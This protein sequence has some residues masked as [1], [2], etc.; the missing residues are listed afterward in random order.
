MSKFDNSRQASFRIEQPIS[1]TVL[2]IQVTAIRHQ[3]GR[4]GLCKAAQRHIDVARCCCRCRTNVGWA[5]RLEHAASPFFSFHDIRQIV[6]AYRRPIIQSVSDAVT[7]DTPPPFEAADSLIADGALESAH[8]VFANR[9]ATLTVP[10]LLLPLIDSF[11]IA[12]GSG[13][14]AGATDSCA[15]VPIRVLAVLIFWAGLYQLASCVVGQRSQFSGRVARAASG[16]IL[17]VAVG[18]VMIAQVFFWAFVAVSGHT[19]SAGT[20]AFVLNNVS[21]LVRHL[22]QTSPAVAIGL[23]ATTI[24]ASV[25]TMWLLVATGNDRPRGIPFRRLVFGILLLGAWQVVSGIAASRTPPDAYLGREGTSIGDAM[26]T[27]VLEKL[28]PRPRSTVPALRMSKRPSVIVILVESL[29]HDLLATDP[30]AIPFMRSIY[31]NQIGF[32][33][34]YA[35]ASHSNLSD[36]AFWYSQYPLRSRGKEQFPVDADWRGESLF[37][38]FKLNGYKTAYVSSQNELWGGMIN[39]LKTPALDYFFDS[40][41]FAGDTWENFDDDPGL[42]GLIKKGIAKAGKIEDSRTLDVAKRWLDS[43]GGDEAFFLGMNLQNTHFSYVVT[44]GAVEPYQPADLGFRAVYYRWPKEKRANV[45]NRYL[46][47]VLN[48]DQLLGDFAKYL[49]AKGIWDDILFVVI[50][51]NGEAFYEHGFGNHSGPMYDEVVRT[52][53]FMKLPKSAGLRVGNITRPVSHI[54]IAASIPAIVGIERP[55]SF[56]GRSV[57]EAGCSERPI[58]MYSNALVRQYGIVSGP[59]KYLMTEFPNASRELYNLVDDPHERV[60]TVNENGAKAAS[61]EKALLHWISI[62]RR[63]FAESVYIDK[64]VPDYCSR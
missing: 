60:N 41:S 39:W 62:Q 29:R 8:P 10:L 26:H 14:S 31:E 19:P 4:F 40:E 53:A 9:L 36:L 50:G 48:V 49:K 37:E 55:W 21:R 11:A 56:Q 47:S 33:R 24:F 52:L 63:Y 61:L 42:G 54:D 38:V 32:S 28:R 35:T 7:D 15:V 58:F 5:S 34:A 1:V 57:F 3:P 18:L 25:V 6:H 22:L 46:N 45:R 51:D 13:C 12:H 27:M 44:P 64:V 43:L 20:L 23:L 30:E 17:L 2:A 16:L 59:W